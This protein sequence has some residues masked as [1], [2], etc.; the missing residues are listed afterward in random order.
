MTNWFIIAII[1]A[2]VLLFIGK[3]LGPRPIPKRLK[4][5]GWF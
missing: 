5:N 1:E 2:A 4:G 3:V